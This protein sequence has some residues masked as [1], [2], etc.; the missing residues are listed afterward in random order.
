MSPRHPDVER[1]YWPV[2]Q[3]RAWQLD[4]LRETVARASRSRF[5]APAL[6]GR[7]IESLEDLATLP[8]TR[9]EDLR[10]H[11]PDGLVAV[12]EEELFQYHESYGTT[13]TPVSSWL[14][15][16]D[17]IGYATQINH[18]AVDLNATDRVLV[19]FPYAIS[20][21]AHILTQAAHQRGACVV[22]VSSRTGIAPYSRVIELLR[23]LRVTVLGCLPTEAIWLAE[24]ARLLGLDTSR[25]FPHLRALCVAG[26]LLSDARRVRLDRLWDARVYNMYGCTEAGNMAASCSANQLHLSCDHFLYEVLD[27][28]EDEQSWQPVPAGDLGTGVVTTL[29]RQA[30][31]LLRY[32]LGDTVRLLDHHNCPCGRT[33]PIVEHHGR[34]LNRFTCGGKTFF[35]R[36]LEER[37]LCAPVEA[38]GNFWLLQ[39]DADEVHFRV[40]A[41][42]PDLAMY[43]RLEEAIQADLGLKLRIDA[44]PPYGLLDRQRLLQVQPVGKP[45][46]VGTASTRTLDELM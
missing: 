39:V 13:G 23:K 16:D 40:E 26:E 30:M 45:H 10:A 37:L 7:H 21:P 1:L 28:A 2:E 5:Y 3:M 12:P 36:D 9:K 29:T 34:D 19:R 4:R 42:Q 22:P 38:I 24:T 18:T 20:V 11:S 46:V 25:D 15:R 32:V 41:S 33:A 44:V 8:L 17:F 43:R 31:P 27:V 35:V 6:A 14:T